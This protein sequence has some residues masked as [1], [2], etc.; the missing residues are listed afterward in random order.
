MRR[1]N[2][3]KDNKAENLNSIWTQMHERGLISAIN[4]MEKM[5]I[6]I[7]QQDFLGHTIMHK[8]CA[9]GNRQ[10]IKMLI[11]KGARTNIKDSFGK[12]AEDFLTN[13]P[14]TLNYLRF[15]QENHKKREQDNSCTII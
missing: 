8:A 13:A 11:E 1:G 9:D 6:N 2:E 3:S 12:T 7:N 10:A 5:G 4:K 15:V 14:E